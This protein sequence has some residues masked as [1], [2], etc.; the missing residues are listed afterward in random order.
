MHQTSNLSIS[1]RGIVKGN[2]QQKIYK[3]FCRE[4]QVSNKIRELICRKDK[5][6]QKIDQLKYTDAQNDYNRSSQR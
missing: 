6:E 5:L 2:G 3:A 4:V 1:V